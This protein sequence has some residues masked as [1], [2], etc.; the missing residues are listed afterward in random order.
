MIDHMPAELRPDTAPV[1]ATALVL[2]ADWEVPFEGQ[3][4]G[5]V[6]RY[7]SAGLVREFRTSTAS[8]WPGQ[9]RE[10]SRAG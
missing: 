10:P 1:P 4:G 5:R 8:R 9:V 3:F 2:P 7:G 6:G